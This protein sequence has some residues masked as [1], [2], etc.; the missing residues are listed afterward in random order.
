[1]HARTYKG[2]DTHCRP[3]SCDNEVIAGQETKTAS[4]GPLIDHLTSGFL[5]PVLVVCAA[6][7][8]LLNG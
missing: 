7:W 2:A 5:W 3:W 4:K 8:F 1:M 6:L